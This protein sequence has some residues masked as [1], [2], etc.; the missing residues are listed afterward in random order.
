LISVRGARAGERDAILAI[1]R[2]GFGRESEADLCARLMGDG[3]LAL[4]LVAEVENRAVG[5]VALS[6]VTLPG[7]AGP[8]LLGLGPIAVDPARQGTGIGS[9]LMR[10]GLAA[11]REAG[12]AGVVLLGDPAY[13][14]RFGFAPAAGFG[15]SCPW[16]VPDE[17]FMAVE[18]A[19]GAL[20]GARGRVLYHP[21]F[22][23]D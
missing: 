20:A 4:S 2:A 22:E 15:L 12:W 3:A 7:P 11:A 17:H 19:P 6:P 9:A 8:R 18:L 13:Y 16:D 21:A 5:H 10:A 23:P 1:H 14:G